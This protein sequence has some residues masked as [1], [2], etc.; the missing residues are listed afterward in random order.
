MVYWRLGVL[1]FL[2]L[3]KISELVFGLVKIVNMG[4]VRSMF[5]VMGLDEVGVFVRLVIV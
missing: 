5:I 4:V 2:L 3:L 1:E